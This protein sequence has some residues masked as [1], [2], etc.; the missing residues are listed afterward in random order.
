MDSDIKKRK[1]KLIKFKQRIRKEIQEIEGICWVTKGT[2]IENYLN[3][4][5]IFEAYKKDKLPD[6]G[7][8]EKL[9]DYLNSNIKNKEGDKFQSKKVLY[10][11]KFLE[12]M[13]LANLENNLDLKE[14]MKTIIQYIKDCNRIKE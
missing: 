4:E 7:Q 9:R 11:E 6:L 12:H 3:K 1:A 14:K 5:I 2:E 8:F 13:N 10:A